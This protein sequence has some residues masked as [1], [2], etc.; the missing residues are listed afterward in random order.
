M[1]EFIYFIIQGKKMENNEKNEVVVTDIK[2]PFMSMVVFMIKW[3]IASIPAI[4]IL[5]ILFMIMAA[6]FGSIG[7][8]L[9]GY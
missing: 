5:S 3:V 1:L 7:T 9:R 2:M 6:V 8:S 4:I